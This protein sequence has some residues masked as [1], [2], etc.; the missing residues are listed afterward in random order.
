MA[1]LI[2]GLMHVG[3]RCADIARAAAFYRSLGFEPRQTLALAGPV[4]VQFLQ[5]GELALELYQLPAGGQPRPAS[6]YGIDH[7]ALR[8]ADL[9]ATQ[10][11][12]AELGYPVIEGPTLHPSGA[13]GVRYLMIAGPDGE[14]VEFSQP[15]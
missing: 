8:V 4:A 5:L 11:W 1:H 15:L 12:L 14:R 13:N 9:A 7:I 2:N 3:L 10:R 6:A